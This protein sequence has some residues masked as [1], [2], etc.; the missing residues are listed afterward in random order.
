M[1]IYP[2][3]K[4]ALCKCKETHKTYGV[5][6]EQ[7]SN[8]WKYTWAFPI[9]EN[10]AKRE[11]YDATILK[12]TL[13]QDTEYPGC[14]YCGAK[15]FIVCGTCGKL[16]CNTGIIAGKFTCE[17]CSTIGEIVGYDGSGVKSGGD[18]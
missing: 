11:G 10:V 5:R 16:N 8:G 13:V 17:W 14:P 4:I 15:Y 7:M 6:F 1:Q 9:K 18:L 2:E 3:A 12:G